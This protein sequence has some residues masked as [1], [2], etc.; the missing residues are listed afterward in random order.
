MAIGR[1]APTPFVGVDLTAD[2]RPTDLAAL[3]R[4]GTVVSF[5]QAVTDDELSEALRGLGARVAAVDSPMGLP[6][7]LCCLEESCA[8]APTG[9]TGRSAERE[10]AKL[11]I[12]CFWTTKRSIIKRMVYRAIRLKSRWEDEGI[13]VIEVFPYAVKRIMLG[14][15]LPKKSTPDGVARLVAGARA[16]LPECRWPDYWAPGHDQL[17]ALYCA[18]T[19]RLYALGETEALGDPAEVPIIIPRRP[20]RSRAE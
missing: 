9:G 14:R 4:G 11:G 3:N 5:S 16:A 1:R 10:L 13:E 15:A 18:I 2:A 6:A 17:D 8:C 20:V 12:P 7:G 19:A